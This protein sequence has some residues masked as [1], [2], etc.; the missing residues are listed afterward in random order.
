LRLSEIC[1][2]IVDCEHKTAPEGDGYALSVGTRAMKDGRLVIEA[3]KRLSKETYIGWSR[4][5]VPMEGDLV[6]AREAPVGQVVRVPRR[7]RI[8]L[9]QRTVL[10]R[11]DVARVHPR[12]LHYWL[13]GSDAQRQMTGQAAGATVPHL[14]V[15]DIR[16]LDVSKLPQNREHQHAVAETLGAIDDLI[17]NNRQRVQVLEEMARAIYRE[18]FVH[19]RCPGQEKVTL[20]E[21]ALGPIPQGWLVQPVAAIASEQRH[22][23]TSGPF[24]SKLGRK[25]YRD[26]GVPVLRG[27]NLRVGGGFDEADLVYVSEEKADELRSSLTGAG[28][29]VITQRG[30]LGQVGMIPP[31]PRFERYVL[32]QSQMKITTE[33]KV[34]AP[35]FVYAQMSSEETTR[36]FV[37]QAITAGVPHVNLAL[38]RDFQIVVP[39]IAVQRMFTDTADPL[40]ADALALRSQRLTLVALRDL[41][42]PKL[43]TG[44]ID[45]PSLNLDVLIE[46][47]VA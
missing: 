27:A 25:D 39:P 6:L 15:E 24:G 18:W 29:I 14:N 1:T 43:V 45:V 38:L 3:C 31:H 34:A 13:L 12:F 10:I 19:F 33:A 23:V 9:G 11:P 8:C 41:L 30:T 40:W 7:P 42:L 35:G 36:R 46:G 5:M 20:A 26:Q 32:S 16:R 4:R 22:A 28:D 21:S 37:A 17:E 44:E 2:A 47:A